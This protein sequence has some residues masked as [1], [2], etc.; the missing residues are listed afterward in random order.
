MTK[1]SGMSLAGGAVLFAMAT[2]SIANAFNRFVDLDDRS[3]STIT[4]FHT[5]GSQPARGGMTMFAA[6]PS[7]ER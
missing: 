2:L 1:N 6:L 3:D 5:A 7:R 4:Q